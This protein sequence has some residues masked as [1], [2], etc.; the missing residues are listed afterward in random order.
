MTVRSRDGPYD[1]GCYFLRADH[2]PF[3]EIFTSTGFTTLRVLNASAFACLV[4]L[5]LWRLFVFAKRDQGLKL[6]W[7][8]HVAHVALVLE[9]IA[10]MRKLCSLSLWQLVDL[11]QPCSTRH[12]QRLGAIHLQFHLPNSISRRLWHVQHRPVSDHNTADLFLLVPSPLMLDNTHQCNRRSILANSDFKILIWL[13]S[14]RI[15][16]TAGTF[17]VALFALTISFIVEF[18]GGVTNLVLA[19]TLIILVVCTMLAIAGMPKVNRQ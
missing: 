13:D 2:N 15:K 12:L 5:A 17:V 11:S 14:P 10:N 16:T 19:A 9:A 1:P 18:S 4:V 6:F 7:H 8:P 3:G